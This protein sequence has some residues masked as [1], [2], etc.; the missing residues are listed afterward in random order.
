MR[1]SATLIELAAA[2]ARERA[3]GRGEEPE[4]PAGTGRHLSEPLIPTGGPIVYPP[5]DAGAG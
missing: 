1:D 4:V 5:D 2:D 3:A